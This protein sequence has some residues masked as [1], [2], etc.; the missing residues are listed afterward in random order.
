MHNNAN[1]DNDFC[2]DFKKA[3]NTPTELT[4][5]KANDA[6]ETKAN[7]LITRLAS[8]SPETTDIKGRVERM[9]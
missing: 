3:V 1:I 8:L 5:P 4:K 7:V 6:F 2:S 9:R